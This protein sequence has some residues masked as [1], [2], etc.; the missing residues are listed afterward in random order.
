MRFIDPKSFLQRI[1]IGVDFGPKPPTLEHLVGPFYIL[2]TPGHGYRSGTQW[3]Y[4]RAGHE[5]VYLRLD[6]G[7]TGW[8]TFAKTR[9]NVDYSKEGRFLKSDRS[10]WLVDATN[11]FIESLHTP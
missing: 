10:K 9:V 11:F 2:H 7:H 5:M 4:G 6:D 1:Q 3:R 8:N